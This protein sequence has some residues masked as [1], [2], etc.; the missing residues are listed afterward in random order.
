MRAPASTN[1]FDKNQKKQSNRYRINVC[2]VLSTPRCRVTKKWFFIG[3]GNRL[4][5]IC[6]CNHILKYVQAERSF[7]LEVSQ[8]IPKC[9]DMDVDV[10]H[11]A[12]GCL[13][14]WGADDTCSIW[15]NRWAGKVVICDYQC[16]TD[17][18]AHSILLWHWWQNT[19]ATTCDKN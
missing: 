19:K 4:F 14:V 6:I 12:I 16:K 10:M 13:C 9:I 5:Q 7:W 3:I 1:R 11:V 2:K 17:F 15:C 18:W 8:R